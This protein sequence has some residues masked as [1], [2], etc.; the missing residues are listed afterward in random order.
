[1]KI[2]AL[3]FPV[4]L[5]VGGAAAA[6]S[7]DVG[8]P[9]WTIFVPNAFMP[10]PQL[11]MSAY[12]EFTAAGR[13]VAP[14]T[15][16][17]PVFFVAQSK[18]YQPMGDGVAGDHPP[19]AAELDRF[20]YQALAAQGYL[21]AKEVS[22]APGLA[23]IYFWGV[24]YNMDRDLAALFPEKHEQ[25]LLE[26][27][28]L[29]G[30]KRYA[31]DLALQMQFGVSLADHSV[32]KDFLR[33]QASSDLYYV[34]V[35]AYDY[36]RLARGEHQLLWRT[37]LTVTAQGVSMHEALPPLIVTGGEYFGREMTETVALRRNVRRGTVTLG[38]LKVIESDV[39]LPPPKK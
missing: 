30:G 4:L 17:Q 28:A 18:G 27:A 15:P 13:N 36:T 21:P 35:S 5:L 29:V 20:L 23:L 34:V 37:T 8:S 9:W 6:P 19:V 16:A 39:A 31:H 32:Y 24:H 25:Y 33:N 1:M 3:L 14:A 38:P 26:R 7:D 2:R 11:E 10:N 12:T 22:P